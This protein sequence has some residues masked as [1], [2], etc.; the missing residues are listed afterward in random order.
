MLCPGNSESTLY[1]LFGLCVAFG[2]YDE[3]IKINH[4]DVEQAF[5][6]DQKISSF[7]FSHFVV[8]PKCGEDVTVGR[9]GKGRE[10]KAKHN[11][12]PVGN[13]VLFKSLNRQ[14]VYA[15]T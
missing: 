7:R 14:K 1:I 5:S 4:S 2:T 9:L 3:N 13:R 15:A 12:N 10:T 11:N 6:E 8:I